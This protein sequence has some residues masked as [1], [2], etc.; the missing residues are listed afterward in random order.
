MKEDFLSKLDDGQ[1]K[2]VTS[3]NSRILC[4]AGAGSGKTRVLTTRIFYLIQKFKIRPEN[5]LAITF[6]K[7]AARE[8][9]L[10][11]SLLGTDIKDLWCRTFHSACYRILR[12][13]SNKKEISQNFKVA[14][15]ITQDKIMKQCIADLQKNRDFAYNLNSFIEENN[16][17]LDLFFEETY[18]LIKECKSRFISL[19]DLVEKAKKVRDDEAREFLRLVYLIFKSYQERLKKLN[20]FDF[21]DLM[22]RVIFLLENDKSVSGHYQKRF[23]FIL[24]DEFQDVNLS[25]V[26]L[27]E[28][29]CS[30]KN[31]LFVVGDDWQ[32][33][34]GFRGGDVHHILDFKKVYPDCE[35]IILPYNYRSDGNIVNAASRVI[36]N[37]SRQ[38]RKKIKAF[39]PANGKI[40]IVR[41]EDKARGD[42]FVTDTI[43]K[44]VLKGI[45]Q[46][47]IMILGRTWRVIDVFLKN[48]PKLGLKEVRITTVHGAKGQEAKVVFIAGLYKGRGG[49]PHIKDDYEITREIRETNRNERLEEER[50]IFYV[51]MTRAKERLFLITEKDNQSMFV[52]E[53]SR[54]YVRE[55]NC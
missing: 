2:A 28:L 34:Y 7:A 17:T 43:K 40:N 12:E 35:S 23:E 14:D 45:K 13:V 22:N 16:W 24:V 4:L 31:N 55:I 51:A 47:D 18:K 52:R 50:R 30:A 41:A 33:I 11:L 8:M 49:F 21:S 27:L 36:K 46:K 9:L 44:L 1:L 39:H 48:L 54:R 10:R 26:R 42:S 25:Q 15:Q 37:N 6:T 29:L 3:T 5:I 19:D 20:I 32:S 53:V 38:M